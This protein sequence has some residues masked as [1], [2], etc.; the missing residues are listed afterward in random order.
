MIAINNLSKT[1]GRHKIFVDVNYCFSRQGLYGITGPS[2]CGKTTLLRILL[3]LETYDG[4]VKVINEELIDKTDEQKCHYRRKTIGLISQNFD[5]FTDDTVYQNVSLPMSLSGYDNPQL[6]KR[7]VN[8]L[9]KIVG[10]SSISNKSVKYL[11]GGQ[12]QRVA[13]ARALVN[14]PRIIIADE[15]IASLD[16]EN[17]QIINEILIQL[18]IKKL[19][20]VVSHDVESLKKMANYIIYIDNYRFE[21]I[22][23]V[24]N[25]TVKNTILLSHLI[26]SPRHGGLPIAFCLRQCFRDYRA[27][28]TRSMIANFMMSLGLV[29]VGLSLLIGST[30]KDKILQVYSSLIETNSILMTSKTNN[31]LYRDIYA[32]N[33][34]EVNQIVHRHN[35]L[36]NGI[37]VSYFAD[38]ET[39]FKHQ[40]EL[41]VANTP[42][43]QI[44]P[45]FSARHI[46]EYIWLEQLTINETVFDNLF[47]ED[48]EIILGLPIEDMRIMASVFTIARNSHS[49][50]EYIAYNDI[51]LAFGF[52]NYDWGYEDEQIVK[53][54]GVYPSDVPRI[55]HSSHNWNETMFETMMRFPVDD[56]LTG[57]N[58]LPWM[59]KKCYFLNPQSDKTAL[60]NAV[61]FDKEVNKFH[62]EYINNDYF[63]T[64]CDK[65]NRCVSNRIN[66][67]IT[68]YQGID[69]GDVLMITSGEKDIN[70]YIIGTT[71]GYLVHPEQMII[72]F[73]SDT[74]FAGKEI[75][76]D[77]TIDQLSYMGR[78]QQGQDILLPEGIKRGHYSLPISTGVRISSQKTQLKEG[79]LYSDINQIVISKG[80]IDV[81][82]YD[83]NQVIGKYLYLA[84]KADEYVDGNDNIVSSY[85]KA[86][87]LITG[88][89]DNTQYLIYQNP[90]WSIELFRD[91]VGI[92]NFSLIPST[93]N[94]MIDDSV[95]TK[96]IINRLTRLFPDYEFVNPM[97]EI[98]K[99][100]KTITNYVSMGLIIFS[101]IATINSVILIMF[102]AHLS[103]KQ[104]YHKIARLYRMGASHLMIKKWIWINI[105]VLVITSFLIAS[106]QLMMIGYLVIVSISNLLS[107]PVSGSLNLYP[108]SIMLIMS[109]IIIFIIGQITSF[110]KHIKKQI[111]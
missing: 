10:L 75:L 59:L 69:M 30:I 47:L 53:L 39:M 6:I 5:L 73:A 55:V 71:G 106:I 67:L 7:K 14:D 3:G 49:I 8:E 46:S 37:G 96:T 76:I 35:H 83:Q 12:K 27:N 104:N 90:L 98:N 108:Y 99:S 9:L 28:K 82:G 85:I 94:F 15:P 40:N 80:L 107:L 23:T 84:C 101:L 64:L 102:V 25:K 60:M 105:A 63:P 72:G 18:S 11:S 92:S 24:Q 81:L 62:Y 32:L 51:Y 41:Y 48:D 17:K 74:Y 86:K 87:L 95:D 89:T 111:V 110:N 31:N 52:A 22:I 97:S 79:L 58:Q 93:I 33:K 88:Y 38:F 19:V 61:M 70:Q 13:I 50:N 20:I 109:M 66:V 65:E 34:Q 36:I 2:G 21:K 42:F 91:I 26:N 4:S 56:N 100:I 44:L 68:D 78:L 43:K 16:E 29:G 45:S 57:Y 1:Y 103:I 54:I 77:E